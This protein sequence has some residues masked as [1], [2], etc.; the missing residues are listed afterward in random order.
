MLTDHESLS[1]ETV[2]RGQA[3]SG[4]EYWGGDV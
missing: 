4:F 2:R 1:R 3:E